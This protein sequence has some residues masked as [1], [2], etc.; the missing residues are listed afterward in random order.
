MRWAVALALV[1]F[2]QAAVAETLRIATFNVSLSRSGAGLLLSE[3]E[4]NPREQTQNVA[5]IIQT[6]RPDILLLNEF[7]HDP[8]GRALDAFQ[9]LLEDG[10][11]G[12]EG[13]SYVYG[14]APAPNTGVLTGFDLDGDG[15][16]TGRRDAQGFGHFPGQYGMA[17]L[18]R[19][20]IDAAASRSFAELLW[21]EFPGAIP[22]EGFEGYR[23]EVQRLSSKAHWDVVVETPLGRVHLLASHPTPPVFDGPE[24][25]NGRRN[26]DEVAFWSAYLDGVPLTDDQGR[27]APAPEGLVVVLGDLNTDPFDG[28]GRLSAVQG[29][30][31]HPRLQDPAQGSAGSEEAAQAQGGANTA[32]LG[33]A[34]QDTA[35]WNDTR[36]PG[37]LRVDYLLP[38]A[39][40]RVVDAGVFWPA[41]GAQGYELLGEGR[42]AASD[43]RLVWVDVTLE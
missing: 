34:A 42:D 9:R 33:P 3:L 41:P 12:A 29:L 27:E 1:L 22:P 13:V 38:D 21:A 19:Y 26:H 32:H 11:R 4:R 28:D 40:L 15:F 43:H 14:Y 30:L 8:E 31:T 36:G 17:V 16:T 10:Q 25:F 6:V 2:S 35:D 37:N 39:R 23:E 7:D 5:A 24:D 20:P 18:S